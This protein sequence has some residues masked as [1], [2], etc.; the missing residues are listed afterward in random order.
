MKEKI[1]E[2]QVAAE[3]GRADS[4]LRMDEPAGTYRLLSN[5]RLIGL[6]NC[7][8][9]GDV[10]TGEIVYPCTDC[11]EIDGHSQWCGKWE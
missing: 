11:G 10:D 5:G 7:G 4:E 8:E 1:T 3:A 2:N 9:W 6:S